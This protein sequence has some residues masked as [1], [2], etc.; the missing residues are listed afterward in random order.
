LTIIFQVSN[1]EF[2]AC[3]LA[4]HADNGKSLD[5]SGYKD[6]PRRN[7]SNIVTRARQPTL[8]RLVAM[9]VVQQVKR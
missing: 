3:I 5:C 6:L 8:G 4:I 1:D 7:N 2:Q 9:N